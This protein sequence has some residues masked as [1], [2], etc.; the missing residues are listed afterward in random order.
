MQNNEEP[1]VT[2]ESNAFGNLAIPVLGNPQ[3]SDVAFCVGQSKETV[4]A[5]SLILSLQSEYFKAFLYGPWSGTVSLLN[6]TSLKCISLPADDSEAFRLTVAFMYG[7]SITFP[8]QK[9]FSIAEIAQKYQIGTLESECQRALMRLLEMDNVCSML[10]FAKDYSMSELEEEAIEFI[11]RYGDEILSNRRYLS[12]LDSDSLS[13]I[14]ERD[15]LAIESEMKVFE[16]VIMW[17]QTRQLNASLDTTMASPDRNQQRIR[18]D[19]A[20]SLLP[21]VQNVFPLVRFDQISQQQMEDFIIPL[22]FVPIQF[23]NTSE[24]RESQPRAYT[25]MEEGSDTN[26]CQ[27]CGTI[28]TPHSQ[29]DFCQDKFFHPGWFCNFRSQWNCCGAPSSSSQG[30][31]GRFHAWTPVNNNP[32]ES[33][34]VGGRP[35][36]YDFN[37]NDFGRTV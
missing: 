19:N 35:T 34:S 1:T 18:I 22:N 21:I 37:F 3:M 28:L 14:L 10:T 6:G 9:I 11:C 29:H 7:Q 17:G 5:H 25:K 32:T 2:L 20:D 23:L 8:A 15:E 16:S 27:D 13:L 24:G 33:A 26:K 36:H 31:T 12:D 4:L 30:C